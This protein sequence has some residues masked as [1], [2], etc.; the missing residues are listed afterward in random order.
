M[1]KSCVALIIPLTMGLFPDFN[2]T[3]WDIDTGTSDHSTPVA[4]CGVS[5]GSRGGYN[6]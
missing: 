6:S 3:F 2:T 4:S 5:G 1:H